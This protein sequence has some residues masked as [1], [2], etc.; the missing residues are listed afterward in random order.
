MPSGLPADAALAHDLRVAFRGELRARLPRL[1][2]FLA[3]G[4]DG[5]DLEAVRR[6]VHTL[7]SSAWVVGEPDICRLAREAERDLSVAT[8]TPLLGLLRLALQDLDQR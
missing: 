1:E 6:D 8:V 4:P 2:D 7:G 3:E 5:V